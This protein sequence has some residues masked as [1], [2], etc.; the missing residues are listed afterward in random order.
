MTASDVPRVFV[1]YAEQDAVWAAALIARL[2]EAGLTVFDR[3]DISPGEVM[4][5][6]IED[7][8]L[9]ASTGILLFS[10]S[11]AGEVLIS[12]ERAVLQER[13]RAG[14]ARFIPV[15]IEDVELPP[16]AAIR[17]P[18]DFRD[19]QGPMYEQRITE[20]I[21]A[22]RGQVPAPAVPARDLVR[23]ERPRSVVLR[24]TSDQVDLTAEGSGPVTGRPAGATSRLEDLLW[25]VS[26]RRGSGQAY[27]A[28][29]D[30]G[31]GPDAWLRECGLE[32][33]TVYLTGAV[34]DALRAE[35][36]TAEHANT[37]L[38]VGLETGA[39]LAG[40]PWETL[41]LPG[42]GEPLA[43]HPR[44]QLYRCV[45]GD[46]PVPAMA[47]PGPLRILVAMA[48]PEG[49]GGGE[50]LDLEA[51]LARILDA[52]DP[53]RAGDA[54]V[55]ILNDGTLAAI[56]DSLVAE[57]YHVLHV[58]CHASPGVLLLEDEQGRPDPVPT[59]RF[60]AE[61]LPAGR[62]VPLVVLSGCSTAVTGAE[63]PGLAVS[64][65]AQGLV[66]AGIPAVLAMSA[67]VTDAYATG[68]AAALYRELAMRREPE[69][70]A[71]FCDARRRLQHGN[72]LP[73]GALAEWPTPVLF[74]RSPSL[75]LY[76]PSAGLERVSPP[77]EPLVA[78]GVPL[79]R[80]G[81]FVGRRAEL[82]ALSRALNGDDAGV[83]L[84]GIGGIGKSTLAGELLRRHGHG[85][86]IVSQISQT[87]PD[88]ILDAL[89][90]TLLGVA[91]DKNTRN[92]AS[93][94]RQ[95]SAPWS[96]RLALLRPL[97]AREPVL[98]LLDNFED[99]LTPGGEIS[100]VTDAELAAFLSDW[101]RTQGKQRVLI[102][103]RHVFAL[104]RQAERRLHTHHLGP[105][106]WPQTRKLM[107]RMEAL[108]RLPAEDQYRAYCGVGGHPRTLE[109]LDALL[110]GGTAR[111]HD[112]TER[113]QD[114]AARR[115]IT[116]PQH[117]HD[118][119]RANLDKALAESI[120]LA[121]D[122][123]LLGDLTGTLSALAREVLTGASVYRL[124]V[125]RL[126]IAWSAAR[127][128]GPVPPVQAAPEPDGFDAAL[129][130]LELLGLLSPASDP[131][132]EPRWIVHRWTAS[133]L[134]RLASKRRMKR[135]HEAAARYWM[136]QP[137]L[138]MSGQRSDTP[139]QVIADLLE[140]R[141][142]FH[143]AGNL[144]WAKGITDMVGQ[145]LHT[146]GAWAWEQRLR[147]E[148]LSWLPEGS[149][150]AGRE[151]HMLGNIAMAR[152]DHERA[153]TY[154]GQAL[155]AWKNAGQRVGTA[156]IEH[157]LAMLADQH[158][159]YDL[160]QDYCQRA[161]S[162]FNEFGESARAAATLQL[163][164]II[165]CDRQDY[166]QA[167]R[168]LR[169][170]L[171][172][173]PDPADV[174]G[175]A[176]ALGQLGVVIAEQRADYDE[177][178]LYYRRALDIFTRVGDRAGIAG[179]LHQLAMTAHR[180]GNHQQALDGYRKALAMFEELGTPSSTAGTLGAIGKLLTETGRVRE[181]V[182]YTVRSCAI[183]LKLDHP[184]AVLTLGSLTHQRA[185]LGH[186]AFRE[187]LSHCIGAESAEALL[188][189]LDG[190]EAR[191][192]G[193]DTATT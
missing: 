151:L 124:P 136:W 154:Y 148:T 25:R 6:R 82:R 53:A 8:I 35:L 29:G 152:G 33:G 70:L 20:L 191:T 183:F 17:R 44:V 157:Q 60:V 2:R 162:T 105:L 36:A 47:I 149:E 30:P 176:K 43:L 19:A 63:E 69:A 107:W 155:A 115:G 133:T 58:S 121:V 145:V 169:Q 41:A 62:G 182:D 189:Q 40:L 112:V 50:T 188:R 134:S 83:L 139:D 3:G 171:E 18:V 168:Y 146:W 55:R 179:V 59:E 178:T 135:A 10:C 67:P 111:F 90:L 26:Q 64:G 73:A 13:A 186:A 51:E 98:L 114:L 24:I 185:V 103:S 142:H 97:L 11:S 163:L 31:R 104:P 9:G 23:L 15:L 153:R 45:R 159:D 7:G 88:Q 86:L 180:Q 150:D 158:G 140:A 132:E 118:S 137:E 187:E 34:G 113:L 39:D 102:T 85:G 101:I 165:A 68:F 76:D 77:Q 129:R 22:V 117:W 57:R 89:G 131:G 96:D 92:L 106:S 138:A 181:A 93:S 164:G 49:P 14:L 99:N 87:S 193:Q 172:I 109:Y 21:A 42:A 37:I 108:N 141:Y 147:K 27:K 28:S 173:P 38:R 4:L 128:A 80:V 130:T 54:Y 74:L 52:A 119:V 78:D 79:R 16:F 156:I 160:A 125:S 46:G 122:D 123:A 174:T 72:Q 161:L 110:R 175:Q 184:D 120:T 48:S 12:E 144:K 192:H 56:R 75:P 32:L 1:S 100:S 66:C 65:L 5:L 190:W 166:D 91:G 126:G 127:H 116:D 167:E 177:A 81:E 95:P 94:L 170:A 84:H 143:A 61:G 71:A